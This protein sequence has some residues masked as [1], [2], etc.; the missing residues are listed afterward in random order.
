M[1]VLPSCLVATLCWY[2]HPRSDGRGCSSVSSSRASCTETSKAVAAAAVHRAINARK[3][4]SLHKG[5]QG[6]APPIASASAARKPSIAPA[7]PGRSPARK[8]NTLTQDT[9]VAA[10]ATNVLNVADFLDHRLL[11][12]RHDE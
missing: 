10:D 6:I 3:R 2:N 12:G 4:P 9:H 11:W 5:R 1:A 8:P 7:M